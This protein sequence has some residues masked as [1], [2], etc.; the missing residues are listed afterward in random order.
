MIQYLIILLDDT[1]VS[2]CR[3]A[4]TR[5]APKLMPLDTLRKAILYAMKENLNVQ[6]V[7]PPCTLPHEYEDVIDTIDHVCI[8]PAAV[9]E[10]ADVVVFES[11]AEASRYDIYRHDEVSYVIRTPRR[12]LFAEVG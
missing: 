5:S 9:A 4:N 8:K 12:K 7:Y 6:V 10:E 3:S 2:F 11:I 1:S